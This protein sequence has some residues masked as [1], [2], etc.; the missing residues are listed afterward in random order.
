MIVKSLIS[1]SNNKIFIK[2]IYKKVVKKMFQ[3]F[4]NKIILKQMY[5]K[6]AKIETLKN[7]I[8]NQKIIQ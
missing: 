7:R 4:K 5:L 6:K 1:Q 2:K 8:Q 3:K